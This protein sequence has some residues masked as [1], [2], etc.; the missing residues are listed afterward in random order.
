MLGEHDKERKEVEAW[1]K[2]YCGDCEKALGGVR[3]GR[4]RLI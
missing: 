1:A 3:E 2:G 4:Q